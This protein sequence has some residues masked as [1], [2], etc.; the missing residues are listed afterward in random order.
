VAALARREAELT[1]LCE[2]VN[3]AVGAERVFPYVHDVTD[4]EAVPALFSILCGK[5]VGWTWLFMWPGCSR[6]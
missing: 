3:T 6:L 1:R 5:W 2:A 4:Y